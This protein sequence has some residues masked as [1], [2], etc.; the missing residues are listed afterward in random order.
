MKVA[1]GRCGEPRG[2]GG[3]E[4][5][6]EGRSAAVERGNG[7]VR[8]I[9]LNQAAGCCVPVLDR[10]RVGAGEIQGV[11]FD[12][13]VG[14]GFK[15]DAW[16]GKTRSAVVSDKVILDL[17]ASMERAGAATEADGAVAV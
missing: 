9:I 14:G 15:G 7:F 12:F 4:V 17:A 6:R 16:A 2:Q 5:C 1:G 3:R 10:I 11:V 13:G 8:E